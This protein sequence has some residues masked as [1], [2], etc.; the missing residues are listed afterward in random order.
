[1]PHMMG[2][3]LK[4]KI[5]YRLSPKYVPNFD[6]LRNVKLMRDLNTNVR[7][8]IPRSLVLNRDRYNNETT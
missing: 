1:M 2:Y 4:S 8:W 7:Y 6:T 5:N 3:A